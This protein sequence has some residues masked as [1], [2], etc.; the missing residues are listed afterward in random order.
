MSPQIKEIGEMFLTP[1][2]V[3]LVGWGLKSVI[4][5]LIT[6]LI[7]NM[8]KVE[9]LDAKLTELI[10]AVGDVQKLRADQNALFA[11][12]KTI[13]LNLLNGETKVK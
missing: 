9:L 6:T 4:V 1:G 11:R 13:E 8:A 10:A 7:A 3:A 12:V 2:V 5:K